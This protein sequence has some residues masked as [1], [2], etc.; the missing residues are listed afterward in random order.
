[1][2]RLSTLFAAIVLVTGVSAAQD[3]DD[4]TA[5]VDGAEAVATEGEAA[6]FEP[7]L[8]PDGEPL[9]GADGEPLP[10]QYLQGLDGQPVLDAEG[11]LVPQPYAFDAEGELLLGPEGA[12]LLVRYQTDDA[13]ALA[14]DEQGAL[15]P[16]PY[17]F[18]E[19][20]ALRLDEDGAPITESQA[21]ILDQTPLEAVQARIFELIA[22]GGPVMAL[23]AALSVLSLAVILVKV[24]QFTALR[25]GWRGYLPKIVA[26][27]REGKL[28]EAQ[29][30]AHKRH[31]PIARVVEAAVR[32]RNAPNATPE[33]V[34]EEVTRLAQAKLD[35]LERGLPLLGLVATISPLLGL[36]GTVLGMI[37]AFQQLEGAGDQVDP[38]ILS[39]GIWEALLTTAAGLSVAIPAAAFFTW[40]QRAVDVCGERMEDAATQIFTADLFAQ[41]P[42]KGSE[43]PPEPYE[44]DL[45]PANAAE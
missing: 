35:G 20:G 10:A 28:E 7:A 12:P 13:G 24:L 3:V 4:T 37:E 14:R 17:A 41:M 21:A 9:L 6:E 34:R 11:A 26:L 23:L 31:G 19:D 45:A 43:T 32:G 22:A 40:L 27:V 2:R 33:L 5:P 16:D 44:D 25:I 38:A 15:I 18:D 30:A 36:L 29:A 8:G 1:M 39:G 42:A